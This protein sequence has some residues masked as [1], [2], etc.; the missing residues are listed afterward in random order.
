MR[1]ILK[2]PVHIKSVLLCLGL[3]AAGCKT[4]K[5]AGG[6]DGHRASGGSAGERTA[7]KAESGRAIGGDMS[8]IAQDV[9]MSESTRLRDATASQVAP[10]AEGKVQASHTLNT[11][12]TA[13]TPTANTPDASD[14]STN[15]PTSNAS[16]TS[17]STDNTRETI[18]HASASDTQHPGI[19]V[20]TLSNKTSAE[21]SPPSSV[22]IQV[23]NEAAALPGDSVQRARPSI[24]NLVSTSSGVGKAD[25]PVRATLRIDDFSATS[26]GRAAPVSLAVLM[27][28]DATAPVGSRPASLLAG[29]F[30][31]SAATSAAENEVTIRLWV[32]A[33][34]AGEFPTG[35]QS[36][37]DLLANWTPSPTTR[38]G[39][40]LPGKTVAVL[41]SAEAL[42]RI[43]ALGSANVVVISLRQGDMEKLNR[44]A[45]DGVASVDLQA[46][47]DACEPWET[48]SQETV[49]RREA[50][51]DKVRAQRRALQR[52]LLRMIEGE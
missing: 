27:G 52:Q 11:S 40:E 1:F 29:D 10:G 23:E 20:P 39:V 22:K 24:L 3:L 18:P 49:T 21:T 36:T 41:T 5:T 33:S 25:S 19:P 34:K 42:A 50:E 43:K 8:S 47:L 48:E 6:P 26:G 9:P 32:A 12:N 51:L 44:L 14:T 35:S 4:T 15:S 2:T 46:F 45:A 30:R 16:T 28:N 38:V 7:A 13:N 31:A 37:Q 17:A